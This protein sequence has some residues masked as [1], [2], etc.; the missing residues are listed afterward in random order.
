MTAL[1][2]HRRAALAA[3]QLRRDR[4]FL[5]G[6]LETAVAGTQL[7]P[8][9]V[10]IRTPG[11]LASRMTIG[12]HQIGNTVVGDSL[13]VRSESRVGDRFRLIDLTLIVDD[14]TVIDERETFRLRDGAAVVEPTREG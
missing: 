3:E 10:V 7:R 5:A 4:R 12:G 8:Q 11:D 6:V 14:L 13:A 9:P 1:S 2:S